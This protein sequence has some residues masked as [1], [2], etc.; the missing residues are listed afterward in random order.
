M[1]SVFR[2]SSC[3]W[4]FHSG[5]TPRLCPYCGKEDTIVAASVHSADDLISDVE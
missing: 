2:C 1:K 4:R 5:H 3:N